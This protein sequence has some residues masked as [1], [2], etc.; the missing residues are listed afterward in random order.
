MGLLEYQAMPS[1][2]LNNFKGDFDWSKPL[3]GFFADRLMKA[4]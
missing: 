3:Y 1:S 2:P 4:L